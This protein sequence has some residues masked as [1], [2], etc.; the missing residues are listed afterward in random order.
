MSR[1]VDLAHDVANLDIQSVGSV[2]HALRNPAPLHRQFEVHSTLELPVDKGVVVPVFVRS[3]C[4][5]A[6]EK[7]L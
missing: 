5:P 1:I 6:L 4:H 2:D 3:L 7:G